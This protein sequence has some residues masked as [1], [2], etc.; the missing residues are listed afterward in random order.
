MVKVAKKMRDED[1][2]QILTYHHNPLNNTDLYGVKYHNGEISHVEVNIIAENMF[3]KGN[4]E[5][6]NF[7]MVDNIQY[8]YTDLYVI[9]R[10]K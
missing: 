2:K 3:A 4:S 9:P 10:E 6:Y 1:G 5:G 8:H 7:Q